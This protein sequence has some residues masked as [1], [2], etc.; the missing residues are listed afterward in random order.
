[1]LPQRPRRI[2]NRYEPYG[3]NGNSRRQGQGQNSDQHPNQHQGEG[4]RQQY[5]R[6]FTQG[7]TQGFADRVALSQGFTQGF[8]DGV[9]L[10][11]GFTQGFADGVALSQGQHQDNDQHPSQHQAQDVGEDHTQSF[12]EGL[13]KGYERGFAQGFAQSQP[14]DQDSN[15]TGNGSE[16]SEVSDPHGQ[17]EP[18]SVPD[19]PVSF[20]TNKDGFLQTPGVAFELSEGG[21]FLRSGYANQVVQVCDMA[22]Q[23]SNIRQIGL[24]VFPINE[25]RSAECQR[26]ENTTW[27]METDPSTGSITYRPRPNG[28]EEAQ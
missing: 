24:H 3:R 15:Q 13:E 25:V 12:A 17:N 10:S 8:A 14:Q 9:A 26:A 28:H 21:Y 18:Q 6:G 1:M 22:A 20:V 2:N 4:V 5:F 23:Q 7:F 19:R 16:V 11:Q 27:F